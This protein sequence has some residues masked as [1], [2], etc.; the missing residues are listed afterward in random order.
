MMLAERIRQYFEALEVSSETGV[1]KITASLDVSSLV[2]KNDMASDVII[3][4]ADSALCEA[5]SNGRN[6]V[7]SNVFV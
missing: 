6:Q 5:K 7:K 4:L 2:P 1:V 3:S